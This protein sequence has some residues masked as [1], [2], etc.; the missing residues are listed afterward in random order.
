MVYTRH[1][2]VHIMFKFTVYI[3]L[4]TT[5]IAANVI[6]GCLYSFPPAH[7]EG[8]EKTDFNKTPFENWFI[9]HCA[10][11]GVYKL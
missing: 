4:Y 1:A 2:I 3:G 6:I 8:L 9:V 10:D 7:N 11:E 5:I